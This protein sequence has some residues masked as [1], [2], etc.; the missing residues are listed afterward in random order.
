MTN[1]EKLSDLANRF[2]T[3]LAYYKDAKNNYNEHSCRI[4]YIDPTFY[5]EYVSTLKLPYGE[6]KPNFLAISL[7]YNLKTFEE[8]SK[9]TIHTKIVSEIINSHDAESVIPVD[10]IIK[11]NSNLNSAIFVEIMATIGLDCSAY[12]GSYKLIDSVLLD[13]RNKIAHGER[14]VSLDLD[15]ARYY[16]IRSFLSYSNYHKLFV[17]AN[18]LSCRETLRILTF[19]ARLPYHVLRKS[20]LCSSV[21]P[22][23][24]V[25]RRGG[26]SLSG[27]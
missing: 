21:Q 9:S 5:L 24:N 16:E 22:E 26:E 12:E 4:E 17:L 10:G 14:I 18:F 23:V 27:F 25:F 2:Q 20:A 13:K 19:S 1:I 15:E 6:M 3:N 11:T 8:S 7:K